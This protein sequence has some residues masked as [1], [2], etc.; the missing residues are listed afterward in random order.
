MLKMSGGGP[1]FA[2]VSI[3]AVSAG[4]APLTGPVIFC[5]YKYKL[6]VEISSKYVLLN[7]MVLFKCPNSLFRFGKYKI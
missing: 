4:G 6:R 5:R 7:S 2:G 1:A 3:S